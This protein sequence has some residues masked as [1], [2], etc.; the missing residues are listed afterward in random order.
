M[1]TSTRI[2]LVTGAG[3]GI[4]RGVALHLAGLGH[5]IAVLDIA[6]EAAEETTDQ[7]SRAAAGRSPYRLTLPTKSP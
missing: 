4:G 5:A 2:C 1:S 6:P 3:S 7:S